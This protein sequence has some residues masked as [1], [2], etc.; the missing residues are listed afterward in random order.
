MSSNCRISGTP[1]TTSAANT[2]S[3]NGTNDG[4]SSTVELRITV[5]DVLPVIT[6]TPSNL[7]LTLGTPVPAITRTT[8]GGAIVNCEISPAL[9]AG[10]NFDTTNCGISGTPTALQTSRSHTVTARNSGGSYTTSIT[11]RVKDIPPVISLPGVDYVFTKNVLITPIT[12]TLSGGTLTSCEISPALSAGLVFS[13]TT[14]AI[15]GTPIVS[16]AQSSYTITAR[17]S[18]G[19]ATASLQITIR[20]PYSLA[21]SYISS[22]GNVTAIVQDT[23][24]VANCANA[25]L[26]QIPPGCNVRITATPAAAAGFTN[27]SWSGACSGNNSAACTITMNANASVGATFLSTDAALSSLSFR[28]DLCCSDTLTFATDTLVYNLKTTAPGGSISATARSNDPVTIKMKNVAGQPSLPYR[29]S[30]NP[31]INAFEVEVTAQDGASRRV[32]QLNVNKSTKFGVNIGGLGTGVT[33]PNISLVTTATYPALSSLQN[34]TTYFLEWFT[35]ATAPVYVGVTTASLYLSA[36]YNGPITQ[37]PG[38]TCDLDRSTTAI[39]TQI[40]VPITV[41]G[42][43]QQVICR[44]NSFTLTIQKT[45]GA[46]RTPGEG[47]TVNSTNGLMGCGTQCPGVSGGITYSGY[48]LVATPSSGFQ[49]SGWSGDCSGTGNCVLSNVTSNKTVTASFALVPT[50]TPVPTCGGKSYDN[51]CWYVTDNYVTCDQYCATRGGAT[52][53]YVEYGTP[54]VGDTNNTLQKNRCANLGNQFI[55]N[56]CPTF[57]GTNC[58]NPNS[59]VLGAPSSG[60][61]IPYYGGSGQNIVWYG[62]SNPTQGTKGKLCSCVN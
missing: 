36:S 24:N 58:L 16:L 13:S 48:T 52:T 46:G 60:C 43:V 54:V 18:G 4:G 41:A 20:E 62:S 44:E 32:Y 6:F 1:T 53:K 27:G 7:D 30:F 10:L 42:Q 5:N 33:L 40:Q 49:F 21:L 34:G 51:A 28:G 22:R 45:S 15:T 47:G 50:P 31:G 35:G 8:S 55:N 12:A 56:N 59:T 2:Y 17:N 19:N 26:T 3:L 14:C 25:P 23:P 11:I 61:Y 37:P 57:P 39:E 9:S 38:Y 29:T